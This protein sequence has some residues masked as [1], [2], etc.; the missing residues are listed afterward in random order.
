MDGF[1]SATAAERSSGNVFRRETVLSCDRLTVCVT[2]T[3][4]VKFELVLQF[5]SQ[6]A[7]L[8]G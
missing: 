1:I 3:K 7:H 5:L 6:K 8:L 4:S 2:V